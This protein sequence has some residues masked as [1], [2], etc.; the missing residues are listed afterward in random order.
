[1]GAGAE[2]SGRTSE[3]GLKWALPCAL[4]LAARPLSTDRQA[5]F[6]VNMPFFAPNGTPLHNPYELLGL[7]HG[8]SDDDIG[9][10]F[11]KLMLKLH[12]DKQPATLNDEER[13]KASLNF[14]N[15]MDAK[16][17]LL[18]G[19]HL[20]AR[21]EYDA[22]LTRAKQATQAQFQFP[23]PVTKQPQT[24][25]PTKSGPQQFAASGG[26]AR[27]P[28][29]EKQKP[30][31][32]EKCNERK[33]NENS[34]K[35][36]SRPAQPPKTTV[37]V[38]QWGKQWRRRA[39]EGEN[40]DGKTRMKGSGRSTT[41]KAA[42]NDS[43]GDCSTTEDS[44]HSDE[45]LNRMHSV[46]E[47]PETAGANNKPSSNRP[48]G[49]VRGL[50]KEEI[51]K[52]NHVE[53]KK[54]GVVMKGLGTSTTKATPENR[55]SV[56]E[57]NKAR[58]KSDP[59][60]RGETG[61]NRRRGSEKG[62]ENSSQG[63]TKRRSESN[64]HR[65][66][67][68]SNKDKSETM[69]SKRSESDEK[70]RPS[71]RAENKDRSESATS[72]PSALNSGDAASGFAT[73]FPAIDHLT[74]QYT[75]P[76]TKDLMQDPMSDFEGNSYERAAI[77]EY[78]K[79]H[80]T[81]PVTGNPL[82]VLHLTPNNALKE[83][84]RYT[85]RLKNCLDSLV[86]NESESPQPAAKVSSRLN[87]N[88][89][90]EAIDAFVCD[91]NSGSP[92][93]SLSTLDSSGTTYG[94]YQ[95]LEFR[96]EVPSGFS[97]NNLI[98]QTWFEHSKRAA[99]INSRIVDWNKSLQQMGSGGKLTF[100]NLSGKYAFTLTKSIDVDKPNKIVF[101]SIRHSIEYFLEISIKIHNIINVT[102]VKSVEKIRLTAQV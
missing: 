54:R 10:Q 8:C 79:T 30:S 42:L 35:K 23:Q 26:N 41:F 97:D 37:Q 74:K 29:T 2:V 64:S 82:I 13:E 17:F 4:V 7:E 31:P 27:N 21:R 46:P 39:T 57:N 92:S 32:S 34:S 72:L 36:S 52:Q 43:C 63:N 45:E 80:S 87:F 70:D 75:C 95:G 59:A 98:L 94:C 84:I 58:S 68:S 40:A 55:R 33:S 49:R 62:P 38:K 15:V 48:P 90:K 1:M 56:S 69:T 51:K 101:T 91:L 16:S 83:K 25:A 5:V 77:L 89:L 73:F 71:H 14:H 81:S 100:R 19:E 67:E 53:S 3:S 96:L 66:T 22:K 85:M 24:S 65:R 102:D 88:S 47:A 28:S 11:K 61:A 86:R 93:I 9:K 44:S 12:P 60:P 50:S 6:Q 78:L 99:G 18:D 76:L 20:A